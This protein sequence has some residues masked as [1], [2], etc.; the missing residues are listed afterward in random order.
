MATA[1]ITFKQEHLEALLRGEVVRLPGLVQNVEVL[2]DD[3]GSDKIVQIAEKARDEKTAAAS[4]QGETEN[5]EAEKGEGSG[6]PDA[7]DA[8]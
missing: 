8:N 5:K 2:L 3:L 1:R 7:G 4:G 6:N